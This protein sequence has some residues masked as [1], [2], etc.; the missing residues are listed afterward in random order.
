MRIIVKKIEKMKD[1]VIKD[2]V[3]ETEENKTDTH[4]RQNTFKL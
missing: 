3:T 4:W 2:S 1:S